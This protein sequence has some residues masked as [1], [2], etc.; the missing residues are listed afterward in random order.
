MITSHYYGTVVGSQ[1]PV[2]LAD[3]TR[4]RVTLTVSYGVRYPY[5]CPRSRLRGASPSESVAVLPANL[6]LPRNDVTRTRV[7]PSTRKTKISTVVA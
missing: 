3:N 1:I 5:R 4:S 6:K 2:V 7:V